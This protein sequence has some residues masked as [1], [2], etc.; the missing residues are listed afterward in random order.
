MDQGHGSFWTFKSRVHFMRTRMKAT[1]IPIHDRYSSVGRRKLENWIAQEQF[2]TGH[3]DDLHPNTRERNGFSLF[4]RV[5]CPW[6]KAKR[7]VSATRASKSKFFW[8]RRWTTILKF[9][10][11]NSPSR[12]EAGRNTRRNDSREVS[13][14]LR[15]SIFLCRYKGNRVS[16]GQKLSEPLDEL[17]SK[18]GGEKLDEAFSKARISDSRCNMLPGNLLGYTHLCMALN[19][20]CTFS[21]H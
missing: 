5:R 12:L 16:E 19:C 3:K 21:T 9:L 20:Q 7:Q 8:T 18:F 2:Q 14:D 1:S 11:G 13:L 15:I 4:N 10:R 17:H 6:G